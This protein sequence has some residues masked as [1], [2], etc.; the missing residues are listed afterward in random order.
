MGAGVH[1]GAGEIRRTLKSRGIIPH[2]WQFL[3]IMLQA[4]VLGNRAVSTR[5]MIL[6]RFQLV[7]DRSD[8]QLRHNTDK[9]AK[10]RKIKK[11]SDL[12]KN[13]ANGSRSNS[14]NLIKFQ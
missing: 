12:S 7:L 11:L 6:G 9:T 3:I 4:G 10:F 8:T 2:C 1:Q 5:M 14:R 13:S